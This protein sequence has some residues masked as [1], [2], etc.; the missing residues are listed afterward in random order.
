MEI[1][2]PAE[3][4]AR[5]K[6]AA[7][8]E[9]V[10]FGLHHLWFGFVVAPGDQFL[11]HVRRIADNGVERRE[12]N[13]DGFLLAAQTLRQLAKR[14][15]GADFKEIPAGDARI[16]FLVVNLSRGQIERGQMSRKKGNVRSVDLGKPVLM[17][18]ARM[19]QAFI[20]VEPGLAMISAHKKAAGAAG[21]VKNRVFRLA[22]AKGIDHIHQ[23]FVGVMLAEFV[24]FLRF[25]QPLK[26]A[27]QNVRA[28][29]SE[30]KRTKVFEYGPPRVY[31]MFMAE[32]QRPRPILF[33]R[34]KQR[35]VVARGVNG[36][37]KHLLKMQIE[38]VGGTGLCGNVRLPQ[39]AK[40][41]ADGFVKEQ[42]VGKNIT[43]RARGAVNQHSPLFGVVVHDRPALIVPHPFLQKCVE[44]SSV[45]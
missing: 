29:F 30:V 44:L 38:F 11:S 41:C 23:V 5:P 15:F 40:L 3:F 25:N 27:T 4:Q 32:Y 6:F 42:A 10:L 21:R 16:V 2:S 36:F 13:R 33:R 8:F 7:Q 9:Q 18:N 22:N 34:I 12:K 1:A 24:P 26:N 14:L 20:A 31:R 17:R 45:G 37:L 19:C 39:F 28:D 43:E 35:F